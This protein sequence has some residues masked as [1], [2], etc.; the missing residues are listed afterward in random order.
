MNIQKNTRSFLLNILEKALRFNRVRKIALA[1]LLKTDADDMAFNGEE[2]VICFANRLRI[3]RFIDVGANEGDWTKK[4][5]AI[6]DNVEE[7]CLY[8][9]ND[10]YHATLIQLKNNNKNIEIFPYAISDCDGDVGFFKNG[11]FS[12]IDP[13]SNTKVKSVSSHFL[14]SHHSSEDA[15]LIKIDTEGY[16]LMVLS[17]F[18]KSGL[19]NKSII[20]IEYGA[21]QRERGIKIDDYAKKMP[22]HNA[23]IISRDNLYPVNF[24]ELYNDIVPLLNILLLPKR[25]VNCID[26][27]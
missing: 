7:I 2:S 18:E 19:C 17:E 1:A 12:S 13:S 20:Q 8:E 10:H 6:S 5:L 21:P 4:V 25:Y 11:V 23:Y 27:Y 16:D 9:P 14:F 15:Y 3:K 22:N 26:S 24:I